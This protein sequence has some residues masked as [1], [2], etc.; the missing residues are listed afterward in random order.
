MGDFSVL[1]TGRIMCPFLSVSTEEYKEGQF[2]SSRVS[3][4]T[5][6]LSFILFLSLEVALYLQFVVCHTISWFAASLH[7]GCERT[8]P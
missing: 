4:L 5:L 6:G 3:L 2:P 7:F 8:R 1:C